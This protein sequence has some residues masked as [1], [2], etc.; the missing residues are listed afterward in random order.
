MQPHFVSSSQLLS[1]HLFV[2]FLVHLLPGPLCLGFYEL[3]HLQ[4]HHYHTQAKALPRISL[5]WLPTPGFSTSQ[6]LRRRTL[7]LAAQ[8]PKTHFLS[9]NPHHCQVPFQTAGRLCIFV[10]QVPSFAPSPTFYTA[11]SIGL[12]YTFSFSTKLVT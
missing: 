7:R 3:P 2:I 9:Q 4:R 12:V 5:L 8:C 11:H 6:M 10:S 1:S